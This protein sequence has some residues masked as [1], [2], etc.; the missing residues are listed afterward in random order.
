[1]KVL[2]MRVRSWLSGKWGSRAD[3]ARERS[4][5]ASIDNIDANATA[6][7]AADQS[8]EDA[9]AKKQRSP[10]EQGGEG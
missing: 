4:V 5:E 10:A 7:A 8:A 2:P 1:M 9:A 3:K 6:A